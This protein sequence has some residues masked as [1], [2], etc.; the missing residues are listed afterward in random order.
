MNDFQKGEFLKLLD[1]FRPV[2]FH[3][4]DCI[5]S[6]AEAH[7]MFLR[8]HLKNNDCTR[9]VTIHPPVNKGKAACT[10]YTVNYPDALKQ[11]L[12]TAKY[13]VNIQLREPAQYLARNQDIVREVEVLIATPK[14]VEHTLRSGTWTTIR[15]GWHARKE[16][17]IIPP[18]M[19]TNDE[20][21]H[22]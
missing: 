3:H 4:G 17:H 21:N 19:I 6:D 13:K 15:Y 10:F 1:K 12:A 14:E 5:G 7:F 11:E 2:D 18:L 8:W 20:T 9:I 16:V 22:E